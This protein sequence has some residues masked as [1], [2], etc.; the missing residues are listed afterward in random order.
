MGLG[1]KIKDIVG[2][3]GDT[4]EI[5]RPMANFTSA[6]TTIGGAGYPLNQFHRLWLL[7]LLSA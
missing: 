1:A 2:I 3:E 6:N 7:L 5:L 4:K